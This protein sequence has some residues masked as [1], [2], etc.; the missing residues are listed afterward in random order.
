MVL[1]REG[2]ILYSEYYPEYKIRIIYARKAH[3]VAHHAYIYANEASISRHSTS[4]DKTT[5]MPKMK[6]VDASHESELS[7]KTFD[8]SYVLTSKSGKV[9]AKIVGGKHK[10][11]KTC[12]WVP[13]VLVTNMIGPNI[14]WGPKPQA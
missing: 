2:Y 6:I 13:K 1:D 4:H 9:V 12:V 7:F 5:K 14:S 8:A 10:G 3:Y 11:S